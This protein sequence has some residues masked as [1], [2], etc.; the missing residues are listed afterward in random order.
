M[1]NWPKKIE[2]TIQLKKEGGVT[3]MSFVWQP[4]NPTQEEAEGWA[5]THSQGAGGWASSFGLLADY[6][7]NQSS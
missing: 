3:H 2:A 7:A 6:L 1:P 4:V 5:A